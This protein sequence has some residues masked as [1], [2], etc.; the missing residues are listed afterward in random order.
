MA[1]TR[2]LVWFQRAYIFKIIIRPLIMK[3]KMAVESAIA[4]IFSPYQNKQ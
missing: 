3:G 4:N 2:I 1:V